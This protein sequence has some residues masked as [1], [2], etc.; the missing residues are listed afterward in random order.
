MSE[1][2][3]DSNALQEVVKKVVITPEDCQGAAEFWTHFDVPMP[4]ALKLAFEKFGKDPTFEHQDEIRIELCRAIAYTQHD[5]FKDEMF[6]E[7]VE[8]CKS[9]EYDMGFDK[10]LEKELIHDDK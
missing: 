4:D 9:V 6:K 2:E 10:E 1:T 3:K 5:A 7:V 8:E